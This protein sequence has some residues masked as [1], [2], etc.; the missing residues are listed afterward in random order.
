[1]VTA[2]RDSLTEK[3]A[4]ILSTQEQTLK[5]NATEIE[6]L[7]SDLSLAVSKLIDSEKTS[8]QE[9]T[10]IKAKNVSLELD[11]KAKTSSVVD[12]EDQVK[13]VKDELEEQ[14]VTAKTEQQKYEVIFFSSSLK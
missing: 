13:A 4:E 9:T 5:A 7:R 6:S 1:M 3:V 11:L 10:D 8:S 12:L 2:E 14:I